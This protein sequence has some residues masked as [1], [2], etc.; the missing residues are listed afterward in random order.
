MSQQCFPREPVQW[1][2]SAGRV[3][4]RKGGKQMCKEGGGKKCIEMLGS[5]EIGKL[6]LMKQ[7]HGK[8]ASVKGIVADKG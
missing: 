3:G 5:K 1:L 7:Q 4:E 8:G 6:L 2:S